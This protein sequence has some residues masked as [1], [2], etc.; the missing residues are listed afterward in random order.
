MQKI[1]DGLIDLPFEERGQDIITQFRANFKKLTTFIDNIDS[2]MNEF[3]LQEVASGEIT[4]V[5]QMNELF[6]NYEGVIVS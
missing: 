4:S 3:K 1:K 6:R 2:S 5:N